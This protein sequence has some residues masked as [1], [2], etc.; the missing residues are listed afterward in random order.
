M[1]DGKKRHFEDFTVG[2]IVARGA[3]TVIEDD[4]IAFAKLYDPQPYHLDPEAAKES[5][6]FGGLVASGA[7]T[8][9]IAIRMMVEVFPDAESLGSPGWDMLKWLRPVRPGDVLSL[10]WQCTELRPSRSR[11][12]MGLIRA[13]VELRNQRGEPV[14]F[15]KQNWFIERRPSAD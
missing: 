1:T 9:A 3:W 6:L 8:V 13:D 7:H 14:L 2:E 10:H 11:P 4:I 12:H 15:F 5:K